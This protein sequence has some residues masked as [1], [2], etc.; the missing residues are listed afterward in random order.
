MALKR[1]VGGPYGIPWGPLIFQNF[2]EFSHF[3]H[4]GGRGGSSDPILGKWE[5]IYSNKGKAIRVKV[6]G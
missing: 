6:K 5:I 4:L 2:P 3:R 1:V